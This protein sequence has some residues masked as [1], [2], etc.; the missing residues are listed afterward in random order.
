MSKCP[1]CGYESSLVGLTPL[2]LQVSDMQEVGKNPQMGRMYRFN[3]SW[4]YQHLQL[5]DL[6]VSVNGCI[7][8][9]SEQT[10]T[11]WHPPLTVIQATPYRRTQLHLVTP[12]LDSL[13]LD[14]LREKGFVE[15]LNRKSSAKTDLPTVIDL[16]D[17][18]REET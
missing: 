15:A 4:L 3:L 13:V 14:M 2:V 16:L 1:S 17:D 6:G 12:A 8:K 7:L 11:I 10:G 9:H 5:G 18:E